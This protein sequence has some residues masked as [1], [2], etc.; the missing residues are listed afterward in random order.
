MGELGGGAGA[1]G[2]G[3]GLDDGGGA[4]ELGG[5]AGVDGG[6]VGELAGGAGAA[7]GA[8]LFGGGVGLDGGAGLDGAGTATVIVAVDESAAPAVFD[9]RTQYFVVAVRAGVVKLV[10][11]APPIGAEVVPRSPEYHCRLN[12]AVPATSTVSVAVCPD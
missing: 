12:G 2:G 6:G 4:G 7:G 1:L 3:V 5:G 11:V 10:E 8:G 9:T